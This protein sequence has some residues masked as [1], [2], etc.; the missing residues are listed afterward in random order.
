M[1][2]ERFE[3]VSPPP[4]SSPI[5]GEDGIKRSSAVAVDFS[6]RSDTS[7]TGAKEERFHAEQFIL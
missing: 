2:G 3:D 4:A 1:G 7:P 6:L 5:E